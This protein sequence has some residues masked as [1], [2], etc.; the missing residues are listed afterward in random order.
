MTKPAAIDQ[1]E[2]K[3]AIERMRATPGPLAMTHEVRLDDEGRIDEVVADDCHVHLERTRDG[4]WSL[5]LGL[6][7]GSLYLTLSGD[8]SVECSVAA[9]ETDGGVAE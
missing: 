3:A 5:I 9:D 6:H 4:E 7:R 1:R 8:A 2:L